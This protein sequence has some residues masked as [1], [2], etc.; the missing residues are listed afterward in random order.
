MIGKVFINGLIGDVG[1]E[2]GVSL[3]DVISQ[4]KSQP[5]ATS[6]DVFINSEGGLVDVGFDIY[7][8]LKSI[9][10]PINTIA[11]GVCASIATV[12]FMAGQTRKIKGNCNFMIHLPMSRLEDFQTSEGLENEA[13]ELKK[14]EKKIIDLYKDTTGTEAEA[15]KALLKKDTF[16]EPEQAITLG[17][18]TEHIQELQAVAFYN[19][20][21]INMSTTISKED[22]SWIESKFDSI[23]KMFKTEKINLLLQDANGIE[24]NFTELEDTG[25]PVLGDVA[26]VDGVPAEGD[27]IFPSLGDVTIRFVAGAVTEILEPDAGADEMAALKAKIAELEAEKFSLSEKVN[28]AS[29]KEEELNKIKTEFVNLK[30]EITSKF[31]IDKKE[32]K[33]KDDVVNSALSALEA[34][35]NKRKNNR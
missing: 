1:D 3:L 15:F 4:I 14:L 6:F 33:A 35:K 18:A 26:T 27:Y 25:T 30:K 2:R 29:G 31:E 9:E 22:K 13:A 32:P 21:S 12:I 16:L 19:Q 8:Y 23:A 34:L 5:N 7:D 10:R 17:F 20:K 24:V 28:A 11:T